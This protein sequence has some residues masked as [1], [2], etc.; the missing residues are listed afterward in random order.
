MSK[1][2]PEQEKQ[3]EKLKK[4]YEGRGFTTTGADRAQAV[5]DRQIKEAETAARKD[6]NKK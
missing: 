2:T 6:K 3:M 4:Q 5:I 1:Y